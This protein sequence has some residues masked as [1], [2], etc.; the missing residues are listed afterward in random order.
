MGKTVDCGKTLYRRLA[1]G[2]A[3]E[4]GNQARPIVVTELAAATI[5]RTGVAPLR[6]R[7]TLLRADRNR[8]TTDSDADQSKREGALA[9][10]NG[11]S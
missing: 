5:C 1:L 10:R 8:D 11:I 2:Y 7:R 4:K 6:E 9:Y 3:P